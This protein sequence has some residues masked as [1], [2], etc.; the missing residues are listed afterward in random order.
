MKKRTFKDLFSGRKSSEMSHSL[1]RCPNISSWLSLLLGSAS[2]KRGM[3]QQLENAP[4][5]RYFH[6]SLCCG[7]AGFILPDFAYCCNMTAGTS[8]GGLLPGWPLV[9]QSVKNLPAV[10]E[11]GFDPWVGKIPCRRKWQLTPLSLPG[12]ISWTEEPGGLQ[13]MGSQR[14]GHNWATNTN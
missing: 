10:Q 4:R 9:A 5:T 6:V 14:V 1:S 7:F 11:T 2:V 8:Y 13:S 12:K 3:I